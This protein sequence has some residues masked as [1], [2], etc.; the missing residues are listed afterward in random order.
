VIANSI[1]KKPGIHNGID[2]L[3]GYDEITK[4]EIPVTDNV[5]PSTL[6]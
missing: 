3:G 1:L 2:V 5:C 6:K 4:T